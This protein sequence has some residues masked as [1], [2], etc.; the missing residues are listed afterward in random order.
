MK[1]EE[2]DH[3]PSNVRLFGVGLGS[4][5][6]DPRGGHEPSTDLY[7]W[8]PT[9]DYS[10]IWKIRKRLAASDLGELSRLLMPKEAVRKHVMSY[11]D[12]KS[13]KMVDS[14]EGLPVTIVDWDTCNRH[15]LTF[16]HWNSGDFYVLNGGWRPE[17]VVRRGLKENDQIGL[18]LDWDWKT[19]KYIF[20]FSVL[21]RAK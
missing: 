17:F 7:L 1:L 16:K 19:S 20:R 15:E 18:Y 5:L 9:W 13:A 21:Q 4:S 3:H 10:S 2:E 12:D 6:N 14:K 11:L 8:D